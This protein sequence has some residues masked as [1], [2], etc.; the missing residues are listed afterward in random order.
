MGLIFRKTARLGILRFN[1][2]KR[3]FTSWG[4][5]VGP[6]SWNS[7]K[8]RVRTDLPGPLSYESERRV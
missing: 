3:G 1:F 4:I 6:I 7:R 5:K 2:S 8:R